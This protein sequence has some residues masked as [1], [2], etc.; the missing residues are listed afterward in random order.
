MKKILETLFNHER[1]QTIS[2]IVACL[3]LFW[4]YGCPSQVKSIRV[5]NR[6]VTRAELGIEIESFAATAEAR[7]ADL[8]RQDEFKK[9]VF[10]NLLLLVSGGQINPAGALVGIATILGIGAGVDNVRKRKELKTLKNGG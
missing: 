3:F 9:F 4:V 2:F 7:F 8:D 1:Y 5:P 6:K 10:D